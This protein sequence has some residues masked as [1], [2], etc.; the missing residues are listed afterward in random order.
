MEAS[1]G[2][3]EVS[4][5]FLQDDDDEFQQH[6]IS[7]RWKGHCSFCRR[8]FTR[9][10]ALTGHINN[11]CPVLKEGLGKRLD[12]ARDRFSS[13]RARE[14]CEPNTRPRKKKW[15]ELDDGLDVDSYLTHSKVGPGF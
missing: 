15:Y 9:P 10:G 8:K 14:E 13:K 1:Q 11:A 2:N 4:H 5:Q 6:Q 12:V 7:T 3:N